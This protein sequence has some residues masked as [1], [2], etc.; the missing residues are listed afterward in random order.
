MPPDA[1]LTNLKLC[2]S[3]SAKMSWRSGEAIPSE[4]PS[5]ARLIWRAMVAERGWRQIPLVN[6]SEPQAA[7]FNRSRFISLS[8][9]MLI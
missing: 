3:S 8:N 5:L 7:A 6:P 2:A 9:A 1:K 4:P